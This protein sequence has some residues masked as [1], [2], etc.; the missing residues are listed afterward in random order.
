MAPAGLYIHVPFCT[1][2]CP[3]CDFAVTIAGAERRAAW[4][5]GVLREAAMYAGL[6]LEFDTVYFGG[7][8]PS[9]LAA[10]DLPDLLGGLR[11]RLEIRIG[12]KVHLEINPE[13]VTPGNVEA[14]RDLGIEF[15]S[16]GVQSF[17][18]RVLEVL[19]RRH[20]AARAAEA[21]AALLRA[22]FGTISVDLIYGVPGQRARDWSAQLE[23]VISSGIQHVSCYQLTFHRETVFG[24]RLARGEMSEIPNDEQA[25]LFFLTHETLAG[26]GLAAYEVSNFARAGHRS[27]H[28][29]KYWDHTPYLGLGPSAHSWAGGRRWWNH[30]KLRLWQRAVSSDQSPIEDDERPTARQLTLEALMLGL[31]RSE[32]VDLDRV[33]KRF[34]VDL[35]AANRKTIDCMVDDGHVTVDGAV[36][37][38]TLAGMAVADSLARQMFVPAEPTD[39]A[40]GA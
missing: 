8:T 3:Y 9:S 21:I 16:L 25:E 6:G 2:V 28:N 22:R 26:G 20:T 39:P 30:R 11:N 37:R 18:D 7:G 19:G 35:Q 1:S 34:G 5:D 27:P 38:P 17:D 23:R 4:K 15:V 14:W 10:R 36:I 32:G 24:R 29:Q 40:L 13:D 33:R 12:A 31:R